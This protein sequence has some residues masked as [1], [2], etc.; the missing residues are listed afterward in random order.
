MRGWS[1][2]RM[3]NDQFGLKRFS[4]LPDSRCQE[5]LEFARAE[6]ERITDCWAAR[7]ALC[8]A[9]ASYLSARGIQEMYLPGR[10]EEALLQEFGYK[11]WAALTPDEALTALT[12]TLRGRNIWEVA[13][14]EVSHRAA[15]AESADGA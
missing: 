3:I 14:R 13:Y 11:Y 5:A 9:V 12:Q 7:A 4:D 2:K 10:L 1:I 6:V 15:D 8:P